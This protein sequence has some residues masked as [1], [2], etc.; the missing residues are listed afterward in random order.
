MTDTGPFKALS[1]LMSVGVLVVAGC[2]I[3][4]R[5]G[6]ETSA[7]LTA[8]Q[9]KDVD[10][11]ELAR[12]RTVFAEDAADYQHCQKVWAENRRRFFVRRDGVAAAET[13]TAAPKDQSRMPQ[14]YPS[15][16]VPEEDKP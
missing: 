4:L 10:R 5:G 13:M 8:E 11:S 9:T 3:H 15:V 14:G 6:E 2:A 1:L 7:S 16:G 12:C